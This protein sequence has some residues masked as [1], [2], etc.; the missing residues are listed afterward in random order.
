MEHRPGGLLMRNARWLAY[1]AIAT[2]ATEYSIVDVATGRR[3]RT[4]STVSDGPVIQVYLTPDDRLVLIQSR[5]VSAYDVTTGDLLWYNQ[6]EENIVAKTIIW[7]IDGVYLNHG[8]SRL[9]KIG[10]S[11]GR[12]RWRSAAIAYE[13]PTT[14]AVHLSRPESAE[15]ANNSG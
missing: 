15:N 2:K 10:F 6:Q 3:I 4:V 11:D 8:S 12:I 7:D 13:P 14:G 9:K 5:T 1:G